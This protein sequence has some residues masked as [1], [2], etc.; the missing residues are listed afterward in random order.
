MKHIPDSKVIHVRFIKSSSSP[1]SATW[2]FE[3]DYSSSSSRQHCVS[4]PVTPPRPSRKNPENEEFLFCAGNLNVLAIATFVKAHV[5]N[6]FCVLLG[7]KQL[8]SFCLRDRG[9][10]AKEGR[11]ISLKIGTQSRYVNLWN[12]VH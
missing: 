1:T 11:P 3:D 12:T 10:L 7:L 8:K 6:K 9:R 5:R 4:E 2:Q